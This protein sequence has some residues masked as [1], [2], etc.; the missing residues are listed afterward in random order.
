MVV[1]GP[2][3]KAVTALIAGALQCGPGTW[4]FPMRA[5]PQAGRSASE[6]TAGFFTLSDTRRCFARSGEKRDVNP[7]TLHEIVVRNLLSSLVHLLCEIGPTP[8]A[9]FSEQNNGFRQSCGCALA[10]NS[11]GLYVACTRHECVRPSRNSPRKLVCHAP[12]HSL[13]IFSAIPWVSR[14]NS[15]LTRWRMGFIAS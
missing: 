3:T 13:R 12:L 11:A 15:Y 2:R 8:D 4:R 5:V 10:T 7:K 6:W 1:G 9:Y 14:Q